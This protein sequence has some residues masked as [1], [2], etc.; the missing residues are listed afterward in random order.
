MA[1][2]SGD[3]VIV[4]QGFLEKPKS[5][6]DAIK[7]IQNMSAME[8]ET[9]EGINPMFFSIKD[10][11][12]MMVVGMKSS[13]LS[14][15]IVA[16]LTPFAIG[17]VERIIPIFG[18]KAPTLF[19]Q[20]YA[21]VLALGFTLGYGFFLAT[22][23]SCYVGNISR[24]MI[25]N[26]LGGAALGALAKALIAVI[27]FNFLYLYFTAQRIA[28]LVLL[29]RRFLSQGQMEYLY[30]KALEFRPV[31]LISSWFIVL[32]TLLFI[33]IPTLAIAATA[34]KNRKKEV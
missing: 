17:V 3:Q 7:E 31:L 14:G 27:V 19:D 13:F 11:L 28:N 20:I 25:R 15:M 8:A 1:G 18:D 16:L 9:V 34:F 10:R 33:A 30:E 2:K 26:L 29:L 4:N 24:S 23:K 21:L 32:S 6:L 5:L 12:D 22:L